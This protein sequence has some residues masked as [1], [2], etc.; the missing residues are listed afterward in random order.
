M[1]LMEELLKNF[2]RSIKHLQTIDSIFRT[3]DYPEKEIYLKLIEE[4]TQA[5]SRLDNKFSDELYIGGHKYLT[6]K[7]V[8]FG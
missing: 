5:D 3:C 8:S 6:P 1:K 2:E 7:G 4:I